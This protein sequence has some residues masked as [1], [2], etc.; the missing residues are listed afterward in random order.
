[1]K[2]IGVF[3]FASLMS[4]STLFGAQYVTSTLQGARLNFVAEEGST[5]KKGEPL[6]KFGTA[7]TMDKIASAKATLQSAEGDLKDKT[8]DRKRYSTLKET[9]AASQEKLDDTDLECDLARFNVMKCTTDVKSL[10][11]KLDMAVIAAPYDCKVTKVLI[12]ANSGTDYG[13]KIIEIEPVGDQSS[14]KADNTPS[15]SNI[16]TVTSPM[17]GCVVN[18]LAQ[19]G[20]TVKKG[21]LLVKLVNPVTQIQIDGLKSIIS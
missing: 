15:Q 6:V 10:E 13:Q 11:A 2:R 16:R 1:M 21:E 9:N 5:V 12:A 19:E 4:A 3:V 17:Y 7:S 8:E 20:Q 14:V 18:T